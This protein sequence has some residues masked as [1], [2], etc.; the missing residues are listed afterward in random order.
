[1]IFNFLNRFFPGFFFIYSD[2]KLQAEQTI[3]FLASLEILS[4]RCDHFIGTYSSNAGRL[5]AIL[6]AARGWNIKTST[7]IDELNHWF[8]DGQ[9]GR[10]S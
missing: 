3:S 9:Y 7:S 10:G 2:P 6:R 1:M 8:F 5:I 4:R